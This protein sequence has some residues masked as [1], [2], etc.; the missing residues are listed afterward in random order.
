MH[1]LVLRKD[2]QW[3]VLW[4]F[5]LLCC[6]FTSCIDATVRQG[7]GIGL[8][9]GKRKLLESRASGVPDFLYPDR[10]IQDL[11]LP[12]KEMSFALPNLLLI[13]IPLE[14]NVTGFKKTYRNEDNRYVLRVCNPS[15]TYIQLKNCQAPKRKKPSSAR[16]FRESFIMPRAYEGDYFSVDYYVPPYLILMFANS[17][18]LPS[19]GETH[20]QEQKAIDGFKQSFEVGPRDSAIFHG[21]NASDSLSR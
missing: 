20:A 6:A 14:S 1:H 2:G 10:A 15:G 8:V 5:V 4:A 11:I 9:D 13:V 12:G 17:E 21:E 18:I 3:A 19:T 16:D 7:K